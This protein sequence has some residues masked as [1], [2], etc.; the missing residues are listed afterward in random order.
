MMKEKAMIH[1]KT[2]LHPTDFSEPS[3]L[4]LELACAM[5][6]D[7]AARVVVLHVVPRP[8]L[9][10]R[11][12]NVAAFKEMHTSADLEAYQK[13]IAAAL[14]KVREKAPLARVE[15]LLKEGPAADVITRTA[16]E[17]PCDLIVM[18]T[19]GKSH[20]H[21]LMMGSVAIEVSRNATCPVVT[22][23]IPVTQS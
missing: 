23:R 14:A 18:G 8:G 19:H 6:R 15:S 12:V 17:I 7:Q 16:T 20:A 2:I 10:G 11:D 22:V 4:A 13:E 3:Q 1:L 5:A 9:V 21:Q